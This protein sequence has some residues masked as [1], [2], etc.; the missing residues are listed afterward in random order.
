MD[1]QLPP[2]VVWYGTILSSMPQH[3]TTLSNLLLSLEL[4]REFLGSR[5]E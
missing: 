4:G 2:G 5:P 3:H 1:W